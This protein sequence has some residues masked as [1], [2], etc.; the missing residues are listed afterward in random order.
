MAI[1]TV[2]KKED[3]DDV[4]VTTDD[5]IVHTKVEHSQLALWVDQAYPLLD[6]EVFPVSPGTEL[7]SLHGTNV[8]YIKKT[9]PKIS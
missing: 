4:T 8:T 9:S 3:L 7:Y 2:K 6:V 1:Y 5:V